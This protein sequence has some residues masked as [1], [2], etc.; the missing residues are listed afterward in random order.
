MFDHFTPSV[1]LTE[2][3]QKVKSKM[4]DLENALG[5]FEKLFTELNQLLGDEQ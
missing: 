4:P 3:T 1:Y 5:R 2:N